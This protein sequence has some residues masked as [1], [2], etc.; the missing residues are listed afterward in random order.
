MDLHC[1]GCSKKIKKFILK[2]K[3]VNSVSANIDN[4]LI[5]VKGTMNVQ[6]LICHL[7]EKLKRKVVKTQMAPLRIGNTDKDVISNGKKDKES[8]QVG[9]A[10][11]KDKEV[12][13][14]GG[15]IVN[16]GDKDGNKE[17]EGGDTNGCDGSND[18]NNGDAKMELYDGYAYYIYP[19]NSE[20]YMPFMN[21]NIMRGPQLFNDENPNA[22]C[23]IV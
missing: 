19:E 6:E 8:S 1:L 7:R 14:G 2:F 16:Y 21:A 17:K 22:Y 4:H 15:V 9:D 23:S 3:G 11:E 5:T 20:G 13:G 18:N 10:D 12:I